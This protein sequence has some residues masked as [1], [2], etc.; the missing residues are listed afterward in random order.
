MGVEL[1]KIEVDHGLP[2]QSVQSGKEEVPSM[3]DK[4]QVEAHGSTWFEN[5]ESLSCWETKFV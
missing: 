4:D 1:L 5:S 2:F 3:R